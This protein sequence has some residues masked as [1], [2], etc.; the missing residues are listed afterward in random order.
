MNMKLTPKQLHFCQCIANGMS[1]ADAYKESFNVGSNTKLN[2]IYSEASKLANNP[3]IS[4]RIDYLIN[5]KEKALV[6]SSVSVRERVLK[7]LE[8]FMDNA[9]P[10]DSMKIRS[11]ELLGKSVGLFKEVIQD[12]RSSELSSDQL[13]EELEV[14]LNEIASQDS[15]KH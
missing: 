7:K 14:M 1:Q 8:H 12:E 5:L 9:Q 4:K 11:A 6:A 3:K 2:T 15:T 10:S 13:I